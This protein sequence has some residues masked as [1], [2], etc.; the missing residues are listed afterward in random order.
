MISSQ[1][2]SCRAGQ[3]Y[4]VRTRCTTTSLNVLSVDAILGYG[5]EEHE[6]VR[7]TAWILEMSEKMEERKRVRG[8][9]C[10]GEGCVGEDAVDGVVAP[11]QPSYRPRLGL[12]WCRNRRSFS[13]LTT[14]LPARL[15]LAIPWQ[16]R[17]TG[18]SRR[19]LRSR[20]QYSTA[21]HSTARLS[22]LAIVWTRSIRGGSLLE[23]D[24]T[25]AGIAGTKNPMPFVCVL[26]N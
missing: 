13:T 6:D 1:K 7:A 21:Q 17:F 22:P 11:V 5:L 15:A 18:P 19:Q 10:V 20:W 16:T 26:M 3:W 4:F 23:A 14:S 8:V 9:L 2:L 24:G 12:V 25:L